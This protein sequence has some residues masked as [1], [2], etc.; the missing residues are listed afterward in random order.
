MQEFED[1]AEEGEGEEVEIK[2]DSSKH[3]E[4]GKNVDAAC[5]MLRAACF[6]KRKALLGEG[7]DFAKM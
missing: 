5:W 1:A 3:Q 6:Q 2:F 4:D 7:V